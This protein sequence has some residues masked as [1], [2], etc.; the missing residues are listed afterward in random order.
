MPATRI[1]VG[2]FGCDRRIEGVTGYLSDWIGL[3]N[4]AGWHWAF[5]AFREDKWM[6]MDYELGTGPVGWDYWKAIEGGEAPEPPRGDN[7][8][9]DVIKREFRQA[10]RGKIAP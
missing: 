10:E 6:A 9:F 2:E 5:Y 4:D 3:F 8:L 1:V 7:P